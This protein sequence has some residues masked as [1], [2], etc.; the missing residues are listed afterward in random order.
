M[1]ATKGIRSR[2]MINKIDLSACHCSIVLQLT[3]GEMGE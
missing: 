3:T 2:F 1:G